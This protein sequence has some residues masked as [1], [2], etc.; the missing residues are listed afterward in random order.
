MSAKL[1]ARVN[2]LEDKLV[3]LEEVIKSLMAMKP[4]EESLIESLT[5]RVNGKR[6]IKAGKGKTKKS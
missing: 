1:T 5:T 6:H 4:R 3:E 2:S